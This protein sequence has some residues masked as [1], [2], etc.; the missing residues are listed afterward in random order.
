MQSTPARIEQ[1][2]QHLPPSALVCSSIIVLRN[3]VPYGMIHTDLE[4]CIDKMD[5]NMIFLWPHVPHKEFARISLFSHHHNNKT[6]L[7]KIHWEKLYSSQGKEYI[8]VS[9]MLKND[10][11]V[12][13]IQIHDQFV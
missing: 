3:R 12:E 1:Q 11:P 6:S 9:R 4:C 10:F 8:R 2:Y 5:V 13:L 7:T